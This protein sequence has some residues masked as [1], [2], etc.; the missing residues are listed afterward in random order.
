MGGGQKRVHGDFEGASVVAFNVKYCKDGKFRAG[1]FVSIGLFKAARIEFREL[2]HSFRC[3]S[4]QYSSLLTS[5]FQGKEF[6]HRELKSI[7]DA[8]HRNARGLFLHWSFSS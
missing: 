2:K 6:L 8:M 5:P 1:S 7:H 3:L 4:G